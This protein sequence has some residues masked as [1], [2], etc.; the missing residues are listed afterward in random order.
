MRRVYTIAVVTFILAIFVVLVGDVGLAKNKPY[1]PVIDPANFTTK[2]DNPFYPL[3]PGTTYTY[4]GLTDAGEE[5][6]TV[7]VTHSTR[8]LMGVTCVEVIDTVFVNGALEELTHDWYAQDLEGNVW[9]FGEDAKQYSNGVL[10]DTA[11][12]WLAGVDGGLPGIVMEADPEVGDLYRQEYLRRVA[13][14]MAEVLS[15]DGVA[16]VP[17]GTFTGCIVTKDFSPLERRVVENKWYARSIGFVKS[18][19]VKGGHDISELVSVKL[20]R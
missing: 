12:S 9:Y 10:V 1:N 4:K 6:N 18:V 19:T 11:G 20:P 7:E 3:K 13:E 16:N 8:V 15:L 14:D 2:I 17:Y 5:L